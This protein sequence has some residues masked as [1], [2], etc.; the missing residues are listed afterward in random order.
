MKA[1]LLKIPALILGCALLVFSCAWENSA[2]DTYG[3]PTVDI[4]PLMSA[5]ER[6]VIVRY[7]MDHANYY[8]TNLDNLI[9]DN[10]EWL[11]DPANYTPVATAQTNVYTRA[12]ALHGVIDKISPPPKPPEVTE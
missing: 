10:Q 2:T 12:A 7:E 9:T 6:G 5:I 11:S 1:L 8:F 3:A 4:S